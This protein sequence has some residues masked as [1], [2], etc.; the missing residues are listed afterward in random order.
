[1]KKVVFKMYKTNAIKN[2]EQSFDYLSKKVI[3]S[4]FFSNEDNIIKKSID[5]YDAA[6]GL[7]S[8][9]FKEVIDNYKFVQCKKGYSF[10]LRELSHKALL[11]SISISDSLKPN[12]NIYHLDVDYQCM[13]CNVKPATLDDLIKELISKQI[14]NRTTINGIFVVNHNIFFNGNKTKFIKEYKGLY[15]DNPVLKDKKG[16]VILT[17]SS[18]EEEIKGKSKRGN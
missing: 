18:L 16:R 1:M 5:K 14:I 4:P 17:G 15:G 12:S 3:P 9:D 11:L 13:F 10:A 6:G 8:I 7:L 2:V